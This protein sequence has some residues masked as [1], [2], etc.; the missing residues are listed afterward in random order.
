[1]K[2][3]AD[4]KIW[5][6]SENFA[7]MWK[8]NLW[9]DV[10]HSAWDWSTIT[11]KDSCFCSSDINITS[12]RQIIHLSNKSRKNI[13]KNKTHHHLTSTVQIVV[14]TKTHFKTQCNWCIKVY[15]ISAITTCNQLL[16]GWFWGFLPITGGMLHWGG[17]IWHGQL[18]HARFH[19]SHCRG[20]VHDP[21]S[22]K[23]H[24]FDK[25][26]RVSGQFHSQ[27]NIKFW[28]FTW[29]NMK[30]WGFKLGRCIPPNFQLP[31]APK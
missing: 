8:I 25:L 12:W 4:L 31:L 26:L 15:I 24:N 3:T 23:L 21:K 19:P 2:L 16:R 29:G 9:H 13:N 1:M 7:A 27:L 18:L 5:S 6:Q 28:E 11:C 20:E 22:W 30:I 10:P 14:C 17:K